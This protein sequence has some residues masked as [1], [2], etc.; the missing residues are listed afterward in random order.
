MAKIVL[1]RDHGYADRIR[2]YRVFIDDKNV[3]KIASG[4]TM[5][6]DVSAGKHTI[7]VKIDW[8]RTEKI[9]FIA[10]HNQQRFHVSSN[11][12]GWKILMASIYAFMPSKWIVLEKV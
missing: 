4:E 1:T 2:K 8:C 3:G 6:Y 10:D 11:L 12:R 7:Q 9:A 5:E